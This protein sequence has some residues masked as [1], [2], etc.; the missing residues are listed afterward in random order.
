MDRKNTQTTHNSRKLWACGI[1]S[2]AVSALLIPPIMELST[3]SVYS[4]VASDYS[5]SATPFASE[6]QQ[7]CKAVYSHLKTGDGSAAIAFADR[8]EITFNHNFVWNKL[9]LAAQCRNPD[10]KKYGIGKDPGTSVTLA[11]TELKNLQ[12]RSKRDQDSRGFAGVVFV[13]EAENG[14][15][16]PKLDFDEIKTLIQ[17]I[18]KNRGVVAIIGPTG[19]LK[20]QLKN[21]L[22]D[23]KA[24]VCS[25]A[26]INY[27]VDWSFQ[28][29]RKL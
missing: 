12:E 21:H 2:I 15:N 28:L 4:A 27:C 5:L 9:E 18:N 13:Q 6:R 25:F 26:E 8:A 24:E 29:A 11:L 10:L 19:I 16:Q 17:E 7:T 22:K 20:E 14:P 3:P 23:E 1:G